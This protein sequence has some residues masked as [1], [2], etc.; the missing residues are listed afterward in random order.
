MWVFLG[1]LRECVALFAV[2]KAS[3][4]RVRKDDAEFTENVAIKVGCHVII[5]RSIFFALPV[6]SSQS[7][8]TAHSRTSPVAG[9][10][11]TGI[12]FRNLP[13]ISSFFTPITLS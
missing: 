11:R 3:E 9:S 1:V 4:R 12:L 5:N 6:V 10:K 2:R 13:T 7:I 8:T